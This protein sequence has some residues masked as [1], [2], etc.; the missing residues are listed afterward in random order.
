MGKFMVVQNPMKVPKPE[1]AVIFLE[2]DELNNVGC[3]H[4]LRDRS[5]SIS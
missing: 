1:P 3:S 2:G 5:L 4:I